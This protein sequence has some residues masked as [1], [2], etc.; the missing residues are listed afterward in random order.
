VDVLRILNDRGL[1]YQLTD[2]EKLSEALSGDRLPFYVG[3]DPTAPSLHLGNLVPLMTASWLQKAGHHPLIVVGGATA[4]VGDPS[5]RSAER[6]LEDRETIGGW[7][8]SISAQLRRFLDF[9]PSGALML[10]NT[11]WLLGLDYVGFLRDIGSHFSVNRMLT[12]D[13]VR[14]RLEKGL[15]FLEFNYMILQAYD[16]LWLYRNQGCRLQIGGADQWGN[17]VAGIELIRRVE[18]AEAWGMTCPLVTGSGGEKMSK[19]MPGGAVWLDPCLTSPYEYYQFWINVDDRDAIY[20]LKLYTFVPMDEIE[21]LV[22]FRGEDIRAVKK[23]LAWEATAIA[24]GAEEADRAEAASAALFSGVGDAGAAPSMEMP[25]AR[26]DEGITWTDLFVETGLCSSR[27]DVRRL[28]QQNGLYVGEQHITNPD[29][30]V[31]AVSGQGGEL[32]LRAG[33]KRYFRVVFG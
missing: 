23:R 16:F 7:A 26:L 17:I 30:R 3:F 9:G 5:G 20:F 29:D 21:K 11:S 33:K 25:R 19:S 24:H 10:D 18:A 27:S 28:A 31:H 14:T 1:V 22:S 8:G 15:S 12:A 13:S 6:T 2:E 32:V 4:L